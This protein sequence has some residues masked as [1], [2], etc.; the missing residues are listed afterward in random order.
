MKSIATAL[1][2]AAATI[3]LPASAALPVGA[4]APVFTTKA[5]LGGKP[6]DFA[7]ARALKKGP[8]VIYFFPAAFTQGC[9]I[10]THE[11]A[12]AA[13][14]FHRNGATLIGLSADPIDKLAK[15]SVEACRNK[16]PVGV[17]S[18]TT[19]AGYDVPLKAGATMTNRTSY[20]IAPD[21]K[22]LFTLSQM[23][24]AGHVQGTLD[25]VKAWKAR[26]R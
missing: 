7:L 22:V 21:G 12:E 8:V 14:E 23:N 5:A 4:Q 18:A 1:A 25:A 19:I 11:F 13:A 24:P 15:F 2:L 6:F 9:T 17:A 16:F 10:E 20:V 3:A 26:K